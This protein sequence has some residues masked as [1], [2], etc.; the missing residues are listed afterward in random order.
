MIHML[1]APFLLVLT[2]DAIMDSRQVE[3]QLKNP[4]RQL[5]TKD[6][7]RLV[8]PD[9]AVKPDYVCIRTAGGMRKDATLS[10]DGVI[11]ARFKISD[12]SVDRM[13]DRIMVE[14]WELEN[15]KAN[16][17]VQYGHASWE[18]P[19]GK[20]M[21]IGAEG[22]DL[23]SEV[24]FTPKD[25]YPFGFMVGEMV[26]HKFMN[27][28]S[29]GFNPTKWTW[30]DEEGRN[31]GIDFLE[32]ELLEW[33]VVNVPAN[34][35]AL[36]LDF[37]RDDVDVFA[38]AKAEAEIDITPAM[39]WAE[40]ALDSKQCVQSLSEVGRA[41]MEAL[42]KMADS[43]HMVYVLPIDNP[44][45][46]SDFVGSRVKMLDW[47]I[48]P[49]LPKAAAKSSTPAEPITPKVKSLPRVVGYDEAHKGGC[50]VRTKETPWD[51]E[52][53]GPTKAQATIWFN[54]D[55]SVVVQVDGVDDDPED[56]DADVTSNPLSLALVHHDAEGC[57]NW[58]ALTHAMK[59]LL[60]GNGFQSDLTSKADHQM[61]IMWEH[62]ARHYRED[63][64]TEAPRKEWVGMA[65]LRTMNAQFRFDDDSGTVV[66][67]TE[68]EQ[69]ALVTDA[70][71]ERMA[72]A[73]RTLVRAHGVDAQHAE[74][75]LVEVSSQLNS[76]T[77]PGVTHDGG[78]AE[79]G[80]NPFE[81]MRDQV[82]E[83]AP[84]AIAEIVEEAVRA[85]TGQ[86]P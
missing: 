22:S 42:W 15:W 16:P 18:V 85:K 55:G 4:P 38:R 31:F 77:E 5:T 17:V 2:G 74:D 80:L 6:F 29:V 69:R 45:Q 81:V 70:A 21:F 14:G 35:H 72:S 26:L 54:T 78:G 76:I 49:V 86:L 60:G 56:K 7:R 65:I 37:L 41:N 84:I 75:I 23:V 61:M 68:A 10:P 13:S 11:R 8:E 48:G 12:D 25:M 53:A 51:F 62:L 1:S 9:G 64:D 28:T 24:E 3:R 33:S 34:P 47:F 63:F 52:A 43:K 73:M 71:Y 20:G 39:A 82:L 30:V 44:V 83:A 66:Q 36:Q 57:L 40:K 79:N 58:K 67:M 27:A 50:P 32:Q 59:T 19:I 46:T